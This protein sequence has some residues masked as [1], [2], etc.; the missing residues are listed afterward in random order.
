[1]KTKYQSLIKEINK[2]NNNYYNLNSPTITDEQFDDLY[3][4]LIQ[5]EIKYPELIASDSPTRKIGYTIVSKL[6]KVK[7]EFPLLSLD[8]TKSI[9]GLKEFIG[10]EDVIVGIKADGLTIELNYNNGKLVQASTRGDGVE[11][12][13]IT[14]N[15]RTFKNIPLEILYDG[16]LKLAGEAIIFRVDFD[17]INESLVEEEKY[18]TC[19]NLVAGSCR[20][21]NNK[22]CAERKVHFFAFNLLKNED[23]IFKTKEEQLEWLKMLGFQTIFYHTTYSNFVEEEINYLKNLAVNLGMPIDGMV[24]TYNDIEYSKSLGSTSKFPKDSIAYKFEDERVET[25]FIEV[26]WNTTRTGKINPTAI[27]KP[28]TIDG[29]QVERATLFNLDILEELQLGK[30]DRIST[31]KANMI[32]PQIDQNFTKSNTEVIPDTCPTCGA[33]TEIRIQKVA[34]FLYCT[35]DNCQ[36]KLIDKFTHFVSRKGM[37]I[38]GLSESTLEKFINKGFLKEFTD[39]FKLEQYKNQIV[40]MEGFGQKSYKNLIE[41]I[42]KSKDVEL[43]KFI[44]ALGIPQIGEGGAKQ[45]CNHFDNNASDIF[46]ASINE[47]LEVKDFGEITARSID[48]YLSDTENRRTIGELLKYVNINKE[49]KKMENLILEGMIFVITGNVKTFKNRNELGELVI[50]L[51]GK[52]SNSISKNTNFL[53]N[54]DLNSTSS[55][56]KKAK[57]LS[58]NIIS[59]EQFNKMISRNV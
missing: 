30:G 38:E 39:I 58:V 53:I 4:E 15:A 47:F 41:A 6:Q 3:N 46:N 21:L 43:H 2:H 56:N 37:N 18:S 11:G 7:H 33:K 31:F 26:E 17:E 48:I 36:A 57:D 10:E 22:I 34:R 24:I 12:E 50:S 23:M 14:H 49:E 45:L 55:K 16:E 52:L 29:T 32:I 13:D 9:E 51:G 19:R 25:E 54:N 28:V 27:F 8:K 5:F 20:Q 40:K 59:E 1:M 35:N 44:F 42:E